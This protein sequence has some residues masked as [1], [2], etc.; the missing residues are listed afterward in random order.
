M[1]VDAVL[2]LLEATGE[3][4]LSIADVG[5]G[6]GAIAVAI[7]VNAPNSTL[8]GVDLSEDAL[9]VAKLNVDKPQTFGPCQAAAR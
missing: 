9:Q 5:T 7:A 1:L 4:A 3:K 8:Y 2:D 6:S